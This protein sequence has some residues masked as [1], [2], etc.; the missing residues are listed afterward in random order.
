MFC[1]ALCWNTNHSTPRERVASHFSHN[2]LKVSQSLTLCKG[3]QS[4]LLQ[5]P[6]LQPPLPFVFKGKVISCWLKTDLAA[7][8]GVSSAIWCWRISGKGGC[9]GRIS[10]DE[11]YVGTVAGQ[12][13]YRAIYVQESNPVAGSIDKT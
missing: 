2:T 3:L 13:G 7:L 1:E 12:I 8:A 5:E 11:R 4:P 6:V 10:G 9:H